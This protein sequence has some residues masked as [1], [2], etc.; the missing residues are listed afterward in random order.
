MINRPD[1]EKRL[2]SS[3]IQ[4]TCILEENS[5]ADT[6]V[7]LLSSEQLLIH[8]SANQMNSR[9]LKLSLKN[10]L[11]I[12]WTLNRLEELQGQ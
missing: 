6:W 10:I 7:L 12:I 4:F 2:A 1:Y 5:T 3:H 9:Q 8:P 11:S